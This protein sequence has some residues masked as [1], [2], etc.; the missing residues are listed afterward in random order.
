MIWN[1]IGGIAVMWAFAVGLVAFA[2]LADKYPATYLALVLTVLG[3]AAG[4]LASVS[5]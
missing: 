1:I 4:Y 5:P 2:V 3:A